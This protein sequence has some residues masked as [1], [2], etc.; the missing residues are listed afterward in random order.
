M[1]DDDHRHA[2]CGQLLHDLQYLTDHLRV[3]R[4]CRFVK[5]HDIRC[6]AQCTRDRDTLLL[7]AGELIRIS[8]SLILHADLTQHLKGAFSGLFL[9]GLFEV[10]RSKHQVLHDIHMRKKIEM[11]EYHADVFADFV[12]IHVT[13]GQVVAVDDD[14][15]AGDF[16]QLVHAA[17]K[18]GFAASGRSDDNDYLALMHIV[19]DILQYLK[20]SEVFLQMRYVNFDIFTCVHGSASFPASLRS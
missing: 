1:C 2:V 13:V 15:T 11:L 17:E 8:L 9:C 6:H 19:G 3:K 16:L 10:Y 12:D 20:L 5:E 18:G 14:L 4:T 7:T